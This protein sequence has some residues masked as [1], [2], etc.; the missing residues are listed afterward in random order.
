MS[1][2]TETESPLNGASLYQRAWRDVETWRLAAGL[3]A[4]PLLPILLGGLLR[5]FAWTGLWDAPLHFL[6]MAAATEIWSI[7][8]GVFYLMTAPRRSGWINRANCLFVGSL[9]AVLW[10]PAFSL[11]FI[12]V[13]GMTSLVAMALPFSVLAGLFLTPLGGLGGW[14]FWLIGV[15][16]AQ[17]RIEGVERVF[18]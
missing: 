6:W 10:P 4:A 1:V 18:E 15:R 2:E 8:F 14:L 17:P 11:L 9:A 7:A 12:A 3:I 16:P 5:A 13:T